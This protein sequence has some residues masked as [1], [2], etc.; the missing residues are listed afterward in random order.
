MITIILATLLFY[1][2]FKMYGYFNFIR[3]G[4]NI[5]WVRKQT[6][7]KLGQGSAYISFLIIFFCVYATGTLKVWGN[8]KTDVLEPFSWLG[9]FA[10]I[11]YCSLIFYVVIVVFALIV[12][13]SKKEGIHIS[14]ADISEMN[15]EE[16]NLDIDK[17][18][19][20][21]RN[22]FTMF[23]DYITN[24]MMFKKYPKIF[25]SKVIYYSLMFI[26]SSPVYENFFKSQI[27]TSDREIPSDPELDK[28]LVSER[29]IA[30]LFKNNKEYIT[31]VIKTA[32]QKVN[33]FHPLD[34]KVFKEAVIKAFK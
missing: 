13:L 12:L 34:E 8:D 1:A 20:K 33:T 19:I 23:K 7:W 22:S 3:A 27:D 11:S 25:A 30:E 9:A 26:Y 15:I 10:L 29:P 28:L 2:A 18:Y 31:F 24:S 21:N 5:N 4:F 14:W 32:Y 17:S 16:Y 6:Y